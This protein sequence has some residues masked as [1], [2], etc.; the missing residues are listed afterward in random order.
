MGDNVRD[1]LEWQSHLKACQAKIDCEKYDH[2][3]WFVMWKY[4]FT[5]QETV[6]HAIRIWGKL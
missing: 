3:Y 4:G 6:E 5:P 1:Y 2:D